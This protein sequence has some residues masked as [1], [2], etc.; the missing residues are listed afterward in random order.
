MSHEQF[1]STLF[2]SRKG[3]YRFDSPAA[4]WGVCYMG[5]DVPTAALEVFADAIRKRTLQ[6]T[7]LHERLVWKIS[8]PADLKLLHLKGPTLTKIKATAQ[9]FVSR[10][11]LSQAWGREFMVHKADIDGAIYSGRQSGGECLA[12]FGDTDPKKGRAHQTSLVTTKL[13]RLSE[14]SKFYKFLDDTG[15]RVIGLPAKSAIAT[16]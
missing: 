10:Y 15:A 6:Y 3:L 4:K 8:V 7:E 9:S 16:W 1:R 12:L 13:G 11:T 14:W 2:F 5:E